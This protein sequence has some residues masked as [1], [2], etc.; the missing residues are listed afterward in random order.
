MAL[1]KNVA[2]QKIAIFAWDT[3]NGTEKTGDA[4]NITA[5]ISK[6]GA[7][8]AQTNDVNP[9]ELDATNAPGVYIFDLTQAETNCDLFILFAKSSTSNVKIEP[10][11]I[12]TVPQMSVTGGVVDANVKQVSDSSDAADSLEE[13]AA[14]IANKAN[15]TKS[16]K[17]TAIRD[18]ADNTDLYTI[19]WS[20]DGTTLTRSAPT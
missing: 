2:S 20:D 8:M 12:Y 7:A 5:Y 10:V 9:T 6:D 14:I 4:G 11:M 19:T 1:Y 15:V 17:S 3:A 16:T 18:R 13:A